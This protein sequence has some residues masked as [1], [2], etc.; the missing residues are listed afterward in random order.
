[1]KTSEPRVE[2]SSG[3]NGKRRR[4]KYKTIEIV[5]RGGAERK[6]LGWRG[7]PT[8]VDWLGSGVQDIG[9]RGRLFVFT[10]SHLP[11]S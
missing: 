8:P 1:M 10:G 11:H 9:T 5:E 3:L 7:D 6:H 4:G 2:S